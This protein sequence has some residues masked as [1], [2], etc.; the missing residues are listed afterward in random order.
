MINFE[1]EKAKKTLFAFK[2]RM[3]DLN[4]KESIKIIP[5]GYG[6]DKM[7][8]NN[9][10]KGIKQKAKAK[11]L[12]AVNTREIGRVGKLHDE[13]LTNMQIAERLSMSESKVYYRV[14]IY[15]NGKI[16]QIAN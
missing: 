11:G 7:Y 15:N 10:S 3:E 12:N 13:G 5:R 8:C 4:I 9:I 14:K 1:V 16:K 2:K 6:V